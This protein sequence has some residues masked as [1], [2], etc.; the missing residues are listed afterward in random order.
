[1]SHWQ[2]VEVRGELPTSL[3]GAQNEHLPCGV[4]KLCVCRAIEAEPGHC[5]LPCVSQSYTLNF[6]E[7]LS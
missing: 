3:D 6:W 1:M 7:G 4:A 2:H 5:H